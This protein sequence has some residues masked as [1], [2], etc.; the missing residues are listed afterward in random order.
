M[1]CWFCHNQNNLFH[2]FLYSQISLSSEVSRI[3]VQLE[4]AEFA[5]SDL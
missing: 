3:W 1:K 2:P 4:A 5:G